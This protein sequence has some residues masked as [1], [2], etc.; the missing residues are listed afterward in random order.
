M[1]LGAP[2]ARAQTGAHDPSAPAIVA[3]L[4]IHAAP[5]LP[6]PMPV[7]VGPPQSLPRGT[8]F[9]V[10]NLPR[11]TKLS[12]GEPLSDAVW[13]V[14]VSAASKLKITPAPDAAGNTD[15]L[16]QLRTYEGGM[17]AQAKVRLVVA[18]SGGPEV[19]TPVSAELPA[20]TPPPPS[21]VTTRAKHAGVS[22]ETIAGPGAAAASS[23]K[24]LE[25]AR[26]FM[27]KGDENLRSGN[28]AAARLFYRRAAEA[29]MASAALALGGTYDAE[30]L[31]R[32]EV[33]G[34]LEADPGEARK[35]Y[36]KARD[37]GDPEAERRLARLG[38]R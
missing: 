29:R 36:E 15:V 12:D 8:M 4:E 37:L 1:M 22:P 26:T 16:L 35:W 18:S 27:Q 11:G 3:P 5:S 21:G 6:A 20:S 2:L 17:L 23:A 14:P 9:L 24:D 13:V 28:I 33:V 10:R 38:G 25:R 32:L 7:I 31:R 30:E 34:I 19:R